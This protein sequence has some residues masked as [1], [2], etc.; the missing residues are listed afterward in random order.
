MLLDVITCLINVILIQIYSYIRL[1][2]ISKT[3]SVHGPFRLECGP[4]RPS[5]FILMVFRF[6]QCHF[7]CGPLCSSPTPMQVNKKL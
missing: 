1:S 3:W 6:D 5:R 4:F 2:G 7:V